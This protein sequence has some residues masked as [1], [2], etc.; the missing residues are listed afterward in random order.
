MPPPALG[1]SPGP[2]P[3][4]VNPTPLAFV[5]P[6]LDGAPEA[7]AAE[8]AG[9][10]GTGAGG[11]N[12]GVGTAALGTTSGLVS[13][14]GA[15]VTAAITLMPP[16]TSSNTGMENSATVG[17]L[18]E[19]V[20]DG[21]A[22]TTPVLDPT[23]TTDPSA[24]RET[25]EGEAVPGGRGGGGRSRDERS[26]DKTTILVHM[27]VGRKWAGRWVC[28][29]VAGVGRERGGGGTGTTHTWGGRSNHQRRT[30]QQQCP[31]TEH[32]NTRTLFTLLKDHPGCVH[33]LAEDLVY[34]QVP[35][36]PSPT[37]VP[38][39][40]LGKLANPAGRATGTGP[41]QHPTSTVS[42]RWQRH[43]TNHAVRLRK[44]VHPL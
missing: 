26:C 31:R 1:A 8:A 28:R 36:P 42:I 19:L 20:R 14:A 18:W 39:R 12:P 21:S 9:A 25:H 16:S 30:R 10:L 33:D 17:P 23:N 34:L 4:S 37:K 6:F 29:C 40:A 2:S 15:G 41:Q 35:P 7:G 3:A 5:E 24:D 22:V 44:R 38:L 11:G 27:A 32:A 13:P 43:T